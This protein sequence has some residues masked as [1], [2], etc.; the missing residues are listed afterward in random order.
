MKQRELFPKRGG[1]RE[2]AGRPRKADS[3]V[4]HRSRAGFSRH[5]PVHITFRLVEEMGNL[6]N[7]EAAQVLRKAFHEGRDRFGFRLVHFSVQHNHLH[8]IVEVKDREA[9]YL[10]AKGLAVRIARGLN[11]LRG[12][13]GQVIAERYHTHVLGTPREVRNALCYVMNNAT[14]HEGSLHEVKAPFGGVDLFS[15]G[16]YF[17]GWREQSLIRVRPAGDPPRVAP[18]TWLL[19][20]GWR[21]HG[22]V[23]FF[24]IRGGIG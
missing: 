2:G 10:G 8:L 15:S 5:K 23:D 6:R 13:T 14:K 24:E 19:T 18:R 20:T 1:K 22:L 12:R 7:L 3:G 9:L 11:K 17:D 21:R 16:L 4:P